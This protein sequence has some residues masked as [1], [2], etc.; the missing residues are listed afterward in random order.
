MSFV[1]VPFFFLLLV[2]PTTLWV[3]FALTKRL[4]LRMEAERRRLGLLESSISDPGLT[5]D[6]RSRILDQLDRDRPIPLSTS[7]GWIGFCG[8]VA[9][10]AIGVVTHRPCF[11]LWGAVSGALGFALLSLPM[12]ARELHAGRIRGDR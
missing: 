8:G 6:Q 9:L 1:F 7:L 12:V 4:E 11:G 2:V 10:G 3:V 5:V